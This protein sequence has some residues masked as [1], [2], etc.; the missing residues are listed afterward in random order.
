[1]IKICARIS[2]TPCIL[3]RVEVSIFV[4]SPEIEDE[5][6]LRSPTGRLRTFQL[7]GLRFY[8]DFR[9][10]EDKIITNLFIFA[11]FPNL[12]FATLWYRNTS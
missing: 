12:K 2:K 1:V 11:I 10:L 7:L 6:K 4:L 8:S 9:S 3:L 5:A